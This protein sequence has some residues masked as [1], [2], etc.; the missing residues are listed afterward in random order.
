MRKPDVPTLMFAGGLIIAAI[1][2]YHVTVG[3]KN[4]Q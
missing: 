4:N 2:F 3:R 1:I